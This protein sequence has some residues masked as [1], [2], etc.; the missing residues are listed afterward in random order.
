MTAEAHD[1]V[2]LR[3]FVSAKDHEPGFG[4]LPGRA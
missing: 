3:G 4:H 1:L 2:K